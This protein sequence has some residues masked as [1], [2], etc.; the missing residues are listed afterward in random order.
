MISICK[1]MSFVV[2]EGNKPV[3]E[4][5]HMDQNPIKKPGCLCIQGTCTMY[6][7][8]L[9]QEGRKKSTLEW[10]II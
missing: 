3:T 8:Y 5:L 10:T 6:M 4:G 1:Q 9:S 2:L 7:H